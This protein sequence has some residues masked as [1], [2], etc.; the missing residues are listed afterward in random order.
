MKFA[1]FSKQALLLTLLAN[2]ATAFG[3]TSAYLVQ[4]SLVGSSRWASGTDPIR[5]R[6]AEED[7]L[8]D[9]SANPLVKP[10]ASVA[11]NADA[12][13]GTESTKIAAVRIPGAAFV[14]DPISIVLISGILIL[15]ADDFLHFMPEGGV[16]K[17][18]G[19]FLFPGQQ[20]AS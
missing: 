4:S 20:Q 6:L 10:A 5:R 18:I 14:S 16:G 12:A 15:V 3:P 9:A 7:E 2:G 8:M 1:P 19:S 13:E 17:A 11:V